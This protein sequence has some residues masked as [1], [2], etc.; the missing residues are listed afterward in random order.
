M[1]RRSSK[2]DAAVKDAQT[3]LYKEEYALGMVQFKQRRSN[4]AVKDAQINLTK[5]DFA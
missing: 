1:E 3:L 4:V 5:E 2:K